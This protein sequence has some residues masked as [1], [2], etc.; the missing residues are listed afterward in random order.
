MPSRWT[1]CGRSSAELQSVEKGLCRLQIDGV[2]P[3]AE[4]AI[5]GLQ[6]RLRGPDRAAAGQGLSRREFPG[7]GTLLGAAQSK[8][9]QM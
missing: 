2:E 3:L 4:T 9:Y 5:D 8:A 7:Q 1:P 6:N